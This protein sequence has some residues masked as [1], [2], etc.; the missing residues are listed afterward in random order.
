MHHKFST[1]GE[2]KLEHHLLDSVL[3]ILKKKYTKEEI[4][5]SKRKI[6]NYSMDLG[7][8]DSNMPFYH[9]SKEFID[10]F[11]GFY[12]EIFKFFYNGYEDLKKNQPLFY[13]CF[14]TLRDDEIKDAWDYLCMSFL[15]EEFEIDEGGGEVY[16]CFGIV[17]LC[18]EGKL[19]FN[20]YLPTFE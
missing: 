14:L 4:A 13:L 10:F 18:A 9:D 2:H 16:P 5:A 7:K 11:S 1:L 6:I 8:E 19:N 20:D 3:S 15:E 12:H 17:L